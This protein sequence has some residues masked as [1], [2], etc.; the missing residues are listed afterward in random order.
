MQEQLIVDTDS[1]SEYVVDDSE[2]YDDASRIV[3]KHLARRL[4]SEAMKKVCE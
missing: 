1:S 3:D 4:M 2:D